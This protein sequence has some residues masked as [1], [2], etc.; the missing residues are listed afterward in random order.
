MSVEWSTVTVVDP[1]TGEELAAYPEHGPAEIEAALAAADAA[2]RAW[3]S[4]PVAERAQLLDAVAR[5]LRER[6][7][8]L[9][10]RITAEMGKPLAE[11]RFEVE[12]CASACA[13][14]AEA[15]PAA[16]ADE[17]ID[18]GPGRSIV[19]YEP[20]GVIFAVMPWNFPLWQVIRFAGPAILAGNTALLKHAPN[21][22]GTALALEDVFRAAGAPAGVLTSLIVAPPN[23]PRVSADLI[24]DPR[25]AA[26]TL[27]GSDRAGAFVA[28]EAGRALKKSV[29]ELGG[30]DPFVVLADA[31]LDVAVHNAVKGRLMCAGQTCIAPKRF[32][33][34]ATIVREFECRMVDALEMVRVGDPREEG[35][36]LGPLAR[37][38]ILETLERQVAETVEQGAVLRTGGRRL[39]RPGYYFPPTV[40]TGVRPGMTA[41]TDE[42]F[43]PVVAITP[44]ADEDEAVALANDTRYGL[45]ATVWSTDTERAHAVARRIESGAVSVNTLVASDPRLPFGGIK[46]SG[47]G[48]ELA[49]VG[50]REFTN[51]R[52]YKLAD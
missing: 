17:T 14:F 49:A 46:R 28:A 18:A 31:D 11:A 42:T 51:I 38:D 15:G 19:T 47:Y 12:K 48:R 29:L 34:D 23:V 9:A 3:R 39:D 20:L 2:F 8:N 13:Y 36:Q 50:A 44:F 37:L 40:L 41:F 6:A 27:T 30:S 43:G 21:V 33:V 7:D 25:V 32:L 24:A 22:S 16:L 26:V 45:G 52:T 5:V 10:R 35:T 4:R 1:A